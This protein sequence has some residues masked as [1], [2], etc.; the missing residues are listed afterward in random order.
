MYESTSWTNMATKLKKWKRR[1]HSL[2]TF[3][4]MPRDRRSLRWNFR[5]SQHLDKVNLSIYSNTTRWCILVVARQPMVDNEMIIFRFSYSPAYLSLQACFLPP[6]RFL[7]KLLRVQWASDSLAHHW[8]AT[9]VSPV[10][11]LFSLFSQLVEMCQINNPL[12]T[13]APPYPPNQYGGGGGGGRGNYDNFRG[14]GGYLGKPRNI[15]Y[16]NTTGGC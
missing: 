6:C 11:V 8:W 2:T 12:S 7:P 15:R 9:A 13:G 4:W 10:T 14:Q 1:W 16:K 3:W 5:L